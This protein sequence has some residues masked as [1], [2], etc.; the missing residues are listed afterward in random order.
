[1]NRPTPLI[2]LAAALALLPLAAVHA[3]NLDAQRPQ[4]RAAL[5]AAERGQFNAAQYASLA[6]HPV[7]GWVELASL[8]RDVDKL[9][10]S[11]AQGFL[12]RY[13]GQAVA[14]NFRALWLASLAR[15]QDWPTFLGGGANA[16]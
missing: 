11:Q 7:Y 3:Q 16:F 4:L 5:E 10:T 13:E 14:E 2:V 1:M 6:S 12:K 15:R 8:R 9:P